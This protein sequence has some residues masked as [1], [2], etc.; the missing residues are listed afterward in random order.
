MTT[1]HVREEDQE[2]DAR[3]ECGPDGLSLVVRTGLIS[4]R[5]FTALVVTLAAVSQQVVQGQQYLQ[6]TG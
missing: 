5:A 6:H 4:P 2:P 1:L 3:L